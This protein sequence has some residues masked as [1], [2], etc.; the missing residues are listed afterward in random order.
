M[1]PPRAAENS[2]REISSS[3]STV[4]D[5]GPPQSVMYSS[6]VIRD[7]SCTR[8]S[9]VDSVVPP[10]G[11]ELPRR[12][13]ERRQRTGAL[14]GSQ[15][16]AESKCQHACIPPYEAIPKV[17]LRVLISVSSYDAG[18]QVNR[19]SH[20]GSPQTQCSPNETDRGQQRKL[21]FYRSCEAGQSP[22]SPARGAFA[23]INYPSCP[24][25]FAYRG[26]KVP[27]NQSIRRNPNP[28]NPAQSPCSQATPPFPG[29]SQ[30]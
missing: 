3:K 8:M 28:G 18:S 29:L 22:V 23:V 16:S 19:S 13:I 1:N 14:A 17:A 21:A 6:R 5:S 7:V 9:G 26:L 2:L 30:P 25:L 12:R 27:T 4:S 20:I 24:S 10:T 11:T 15:T